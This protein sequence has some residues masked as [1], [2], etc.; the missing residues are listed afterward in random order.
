METVEERCLIGKLDTK[1]EKS[2]K[3]LLLSLYFALGNYKP[4]GVC[5]CV[6]AGKEQDAFYVSDDRNS[7][8]CLKKGKQER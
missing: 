5:F 8:I 3:K 4:T 7:Q 1:F 2:Q 6:E